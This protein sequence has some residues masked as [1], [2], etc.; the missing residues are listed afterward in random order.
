MIHNVALIERNADRV[1]EIMRCWSDTIIVSHRV[2]LFEE[3]LTPIEQIR[4]SGSNATNTAAE[5]RRRVQLWPRRRDAATQV[6]AP[7]ASG[8]Y[9]ANLELELALRML[10]YRHYDALP[11]IHSPIQRVGYEPGCLFQ[12]L[13]LDAQ[14]DWCDVFVYQDKF[15]YSVDSWRLSEA[16][17]SNRSSSAA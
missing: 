7:E 17:C 2:R 16:V 10:Q 5:I 14:G 3:V 1:Y 12:Y 15:V 13:T 6:A 8:R 11:P 4:R 9:G